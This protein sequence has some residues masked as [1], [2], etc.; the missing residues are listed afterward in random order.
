MWRLLIKFPI[1][2]SAMAATL[3]AFTVHHFRLARLLAAHAA[4]GKAEDL[5][6]A[7]IGVPIIVAAYKATSPASLEH[8]LLV[9][10]TSAEH[11]HRM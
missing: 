8:I 11:R 2:L 5:F 4:L 1:V 10:L 9:R 7:P 3:G 6:P